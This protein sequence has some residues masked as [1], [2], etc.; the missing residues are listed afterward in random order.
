MSTSGCLTFLCGIGVFVRQPSGVRFGDL[1]ACV[2][3]LGYATK[4]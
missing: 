3:R 4:R 2:K 1:G